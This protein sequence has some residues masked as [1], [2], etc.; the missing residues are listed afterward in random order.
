M[1]DESGDKKQMSFLGHLE[2]L[3]WRL[4]R[5]AVVIVVFATVIFIFTQEILDHVLLAHLDQDFITY[6]LF[7]RMGELLGMGENFYAGSIDVKLQ[8]LKMTEQFTT[9]I[10]FALVG[11][12]V[13][14]FPYF[15]VEFWSFIKPALKEKERKAARGIVFYSTILFFIGIFFG[16]FLVAALAVQFFGNYKMS[17]DMELNFT[18]NNYLSTVVMTTFL[19]GI[20]FQLPIIVYITSKIG[21][22]SAALLKKFRKHSLI[23]LLILSAIITPPDVISQVMLTIPLLGLYELSIA[24][25]KRV[26]KKREKA[27]AA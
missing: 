16:Y 24:I 10:F 2:E 21:I 26:E 4:V 18:V 20:F 14:A 13:V 17:E 12:M 7:G 11:G 1:S 5:T 23:V 19:T 6:K 8:S 3:R 25:A 15:F 27:E 22:V 9:N